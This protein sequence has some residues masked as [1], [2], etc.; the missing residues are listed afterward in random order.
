MKKC[1][2]V[3]VKKGNLQMGKLSPEGMGKHNPIFTKKRK[4][5]KKK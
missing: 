2:R 5:R 1:I 3:M 4:K